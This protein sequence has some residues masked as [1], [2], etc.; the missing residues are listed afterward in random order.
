M[1]RARHILFPTDFSP[2]AE[3]ASAYAVALAKKYEGTLHIVHCV[4]CTMYAQGAA[5]S[6]YLSEEDLATLQ[7]SMRDHAE[8]QLQG[9]VESPAMAGVKVESHVAT[10]RPATEILTLAEELGC[11]L[12]VLA[13]HGR[14]GLDHMVFG[15]VCEKIIRQAQMPVLSIKKKEHEFVDDATR[16]IHLHRVLCPLDFSDCSE[17]ALPLASS[18]CRE[19]GAELL[20]VHVN[21]VPSALPDVMPDL[22][23]QI[24]ASLEDYSKQTMARLKKSLQGVKTE[25]RITLGSPHREIARLV[26]DAAVDLIVMATHGRSGVAHMLFGSVAEKVVRTAQCP[27]LTCRPTEA[28]VLTGTS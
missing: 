14:S 22:T 5:N 4:D 17:K 8:S 3:H 25:F 26:D 16:E 11:D 9:V 24:S 13:T 28:S 20:L 12:I 18:L 15:S 2:H 23:T 19:F 10:G 1:L 27:V 6:R 21:D 7:T